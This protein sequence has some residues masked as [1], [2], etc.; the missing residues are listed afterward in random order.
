MEESIES[1]FTTHALFSVVFPFVKKEMR[2]D[3]SVGIRMVYAES[4]LNCI[5]TE[6]YDLKIK[7]KS[8]SNGGEF[9]K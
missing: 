1:R 8:K 6:Q 4:K 9:I 7:L 3:S 5:V 2:N